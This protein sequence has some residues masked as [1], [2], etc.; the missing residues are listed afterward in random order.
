MES[1]FEEYYEDQDYLRYYQMYGMV[2]S[3]REYE[4]LLQQCRKIVEI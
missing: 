1:V 4:E 3:E 2:H